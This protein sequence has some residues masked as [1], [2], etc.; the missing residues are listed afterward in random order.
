MKQKLSIALSL[1]LLI[2]LCTACSASQYKSNEF[3]DS[4]DNSLRSE[5]VDGGFG[6]APYAPEP[7]AA[8]DEPTVEWPPSAEEFTLQADPN[9]KLIR[10]GELHVESE[11][12]DESLTALNRLVD[13]LGGYIESSDVTGADRTSR[14]YASLR[15]A[16]F[17]VRVPSEKFEVFLNRAGEMGHVLGRSTAS[18]DVTDEY[19]DKETRLETLRMELRMLREEFEKEGPMA[20]RVTLLDRISQVQYEI[21]KL[22]GTLRKY[23]GLVDYATIR[24]SISEVLEIVDEELLLPEP[25]TMGERISRQLS[26]SW[27]SFT[28]GGADLIVW[29]VGALPFLIFW[30]VLIFLI[31]FF[32]R[33]AYKRHRR[34]AT[35]SAQKPATGG[36]D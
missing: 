19:F 7:A 35:S 22:T 33:R 6:G 3:G 4:I 28:A 10:T 18:S 27:H 36:S 26:A 14:G 31:V 8:N 24:V 16:N 25:K 20:D 13:S 29:F 23:D 17:T 11:T 21:E 5:A 34:K 1:V 15:W 9:R 12:F 2:L 32:I 30:G